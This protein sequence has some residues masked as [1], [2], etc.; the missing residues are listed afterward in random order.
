MKIMIVVPPNLMYKHVGFL[1]TNCLALPIGPAYL[2]SSVSTICDSIIYDMSI[3][4]KRGHL[5]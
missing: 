1:E 5:R 2:L 3:G 4:K